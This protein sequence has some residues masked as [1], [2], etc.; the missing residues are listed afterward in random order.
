MSDSNQGWGWTD[1]AGA[2]CGAAYVLLIGVGN[3][4]AGSGSDMHPTGI[5]GPHGLPGAPSEDVNV[6]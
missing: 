5:S 4:I 6:R 1:W 3:Q 2:A